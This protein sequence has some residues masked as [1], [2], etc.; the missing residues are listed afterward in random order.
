MAKN[1]SDSKN[2]VTVD[3]SA[4]SSAKASMSPEDRS[5]NE[6]KKALFHNWLDHGCVTVLFDARASGVKVPKEFAGRG[7]LR[8]NFSY[9]FLVPDFSFDDDNV[10]ATLSF[11]SGEFYCFVPWRTVYGLQS[12]V[13]HQGAV[14][15]DS[16]P[17][18]YDQIAVL[19]FNEEMCEEFESLP[20]PSSD[21]GE[22][23]KIECN[24][25]ELGIVPRGES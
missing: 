8:L 14:W 20:L 9:D 23:S 13:L 21:R 17:G 3:F 2:V 10:W 1:I 25:V 6:K 4:K 15:F 22:A 5:L 19:G 12:E 16:F 24:V 11:D 18:D 7:D